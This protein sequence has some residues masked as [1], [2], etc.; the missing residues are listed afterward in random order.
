[1]NVIHVDFKTK[2]RRQLNTS[3]REEQL[4]HIRIKLTETEKF[5]LS[6]DIG[7]LIKDHTKRCFTSII[8][9]LVSV[10]GDK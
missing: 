6:Q 8:N 7:E 5:I 4:D 10:H 3:L 1:M 2:K 9:T